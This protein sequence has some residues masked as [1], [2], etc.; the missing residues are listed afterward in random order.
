MQS[1]YILHSDFL[2]GVKEPPA[3]PSRPLSLHHPLITLVCLN[4]SLADVL[5]WSRYKIHTAVA[6]WQ[7]NWRHCRAVVVSLNGAVMWRG[8]GAEER[9]ALWL[10]EHLN[11][12]ASPDKLE[13]QTKSAVCKPSSL[14]WHYTS[15]QLHRHVTATAVVKNVLNKSGCTFTWRINQTNKQTNK[16]P[17]IQFINWTMECQVQGKTVCMCVQYTLCALSKFITAC[18]KCVILA[19]SDPVQAL[20]TKGERRDSSTHSSPRHYMQVSGQR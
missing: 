12:N 4:Q 20:N 3:H 6:D 14:F 11:T 10:L 7:Q 8:T 18:S 5:M 16:H 17:H 15:F 1:H 13:Q 19:A 2:N 9:E